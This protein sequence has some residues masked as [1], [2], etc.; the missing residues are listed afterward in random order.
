ME[1]GLTGAELGRLIHRVFK[2]GPRDLAPEVLV[3]LPDEELADNPPWA[4]RREMAAR[5]VRELRGE[6]S[7]PALAYEL[8]LN[9]NA[10]RNNADLP[11]QAVPGHP[12]VPLPNRADEVDPSSALPLEAVFR[13]HTILLA[14]T[15]LSATAPLKLAARRYAVSCY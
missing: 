10:R 15:E 7:A 3:D 2:P 14:P 6:P 12:D 1:E 8:V 4:Q 9:R 13:S 5:W 11:P